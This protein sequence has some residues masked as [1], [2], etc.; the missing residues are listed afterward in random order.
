[1]SMVRFLFTLFAT[2]S[3]SACSA[4]LTQLLRL[5]ASVSGG[6]GSTTLAG[7]VLRSGSSLQSSSLFV[8]Y[9]T[10][11]VAS[12]TNNPGPRYSSCTWTDNSGNFWLYGGYTNNVNLGYG[13]FGDMWMYN[14]TTMLWTWVSGSNQR[15][16]SAVYGTQGVS[17][18]SNYPG[19]RD[20][21]ACWKD[22]SGNLWMFGGHGKASGATVGNLNDLWK[23]STTT[24]QW[25][26]IGGATT[27]RQIG[28][29]GTQGVGSTSNIPTSRQLMTYWTDS[30]GIFWLF[31]G[32]CN[33]SFGN[34]GS[35]LGYLNDLWSYDPSN[36][37]WTWVSGYNDT[38]QLPT[39]G[40]LGVG[41]TSNI[42]GAR[43]MSYAWS[44]TLGNVYIFGGYG[45]DTSG[46]ANGALNDFWKYDPTSG[47]WTWL[48][49]SNVSVNG[50]TWGSKGVGSTSNIPSSRSAGGYWSDIAGNFYLFAGGGCDNGCSNIDDLNDIWKYS[51]STGQWTWLAGSDVAAQAGIYGTLGVA[52]AANAPGARYAPLWWSDSSGN[53]WVYG[54]YGYDALLNNDYLSDLWKYDFSSSKWTWEFG[55]NYFFAPGIYG[56]KGIAAATNQPGARVSPMSWSDGSGNLWLFGGYGFD[57]SATGESQFYLNDLWEY[58]TTTQ[59]WTWIAGSTISASA[60]YGTLGVGSTSNLPGGRETGATW[61]DLSGN[62]WLFGGYGY[63]SATNWGSLNDL[64]KF[65]TATKQWTWVAGSNTRNASGVYG[66][67]GVGST[68]NIPGARSGAVS[69]K[70]S[71]GNLWLFGGAGYDSA[72][73]NGYLNDLWMYEIS[74]GK[75]TWV[76]GSNLISQFGTYGTQ[77]VASASNV[78][79]ARYFGAGWIDSSGNFWIFGGDGQAASNTGNLNDLWKYDPLAQEWTWEAGL[80]DISQAGVYGVLGIA[81]ASNVPGARTGS[82]FWTDASG[83]LW[84]YGGY[85]YDSASTRDSL[86]D[87]WM[88]S[89]TTGKWTWSGGSNVIAQASVVGTAGVGSPTNIPGARDQAA[90]WLD[91]HGH[92][93]IFGGEGYDSLGIYG[94]LFDLWEIP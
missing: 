16:Q 20:S 88:Y 48:A 89:P 29:Y 69:W 84:L 90:F 4:Q 71:A 79:G 12:A 62:L 70:D 60:Q 25:T 46:F 3:L 67:K 65:T 17:S 54:G 23:F 38:D 53:L 59:L 31:G 80:N 6:S 86:N 94:N 1:M 22:S 2:L 63:D 52:S 74:T 26:W 93:W 5:G 47:Q 13:Q 72:G 56:T 37:K 36:G 83:N 51:P 7:P 28:T 33:G 75:W 85:G 21:G 41:S 61:T 43:Q 92:A 50:G 42:P 81:S 76:S 40:T 32:N 91:S 78:P 44:D 34:C 10:Q 77:G 15:N 35:T 9:G 11:G 14:P 24:L 19:S 55:G 73:S 27:T 8:Q 49:G 64:W 18:A 30:S 39:Y 87:L 82:S 57:G 45:Y 68:S 66:T 58:S